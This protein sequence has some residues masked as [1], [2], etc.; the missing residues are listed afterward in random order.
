MTFPPFSW[1]VDGWILVVASLCA[2]ACALLGNFLVLRRLSMLGDAIS[3]AVLPGLAIAFLVTQSR[4]SWPMF[5]GAVIVGTLT[6]FFVEWVRRV[7]RVD[8]GASMGVVFTSMFAIGLL[9]IVQAADQ[10]HLD[11][12]CVLYG[13]I[14]LTP[15]DQVDLGFASVPQAA[16]TLGAVAIINSLAVGFLYKEWLIT[17]FDAALATASG[18]S[19]ATMHYLLMVLVAVTA[20]AS[21]ECVGSVLVV[22]MFVVPPATALLLTDR[23][24]R[25]IPISL[26]VAVLSAVFGH[27]AA[28][29]APATVGLKSTTTASMMAVAAG[30]LLGLAALLAPRHGILVKALRLRGLS[31]QILEDDVLALLFR[32]EEAQTTAAVDWNTMRRLLLG[33]RWMLRQAIARLKRQGRIAVTGSEVRL[34]DAGRAQAQNVV[35]SHRLWESYLQDHAGLGRSQVHA[36]AERLEHFTDS[37]LRAQLDEASHHDGLDPHGR[38]IP[39]ESR[40]SE[41]G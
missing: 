1:E 8:E 6:A 24:S 3:H 14:E 29:L 2:V 23:L 21:F 9:I 33:S 34:T 18:I 7:G 16:L 19:A 12:D 37:Q 11:A 25:M 36:S 38:R 20:V 17:S 40:S 28:I 41:G 15:L 4:S 5:L 26:L 39:D 35:R 27:G 32:F 30:L 10:V 22:A 13:A 31:Q